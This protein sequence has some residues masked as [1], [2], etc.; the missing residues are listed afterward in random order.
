MD[1]ESALK[2][3]STILLILLGLALLIGANYL[4]FSTQASLPSQVKDALNSNDQIKVTLKQEQYLM[5]EP[6]ETPPT[7]G[8]IMYPE[9]RMDVRT[10]G[11]VARQ[12]AQE[13][14]LVIFL[15]RRGEREVDPVQAYAHIE[16]IIA[17]HPEITAWAIGGHTWNGQ[18][19]TTYALGHPEQINALV[20]WAGRFSEGNDLSEISLPVLYVYGTLDDE[21]VGLIETIQPI[22]PEGTVWVSIEGGNRVGFGS[23]GPM[24]ADVGAEISEVDQ[25]NQAAEATVEFLDQ[26]LNP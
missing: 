25:Q 1:Q 14:Y 5:M 20:Y 22:L 3:I 4:L 2:K 17:S 8:L 18:I 7:R 24:A 13:G 12:I 21:N 6:M 10:Y 19:S 15:S 11:Y 26:V 16:E 9:G 23:Y